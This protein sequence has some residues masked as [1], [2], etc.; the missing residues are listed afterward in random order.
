MKSNL[1][2]SLFA[3]SAVVPFAAVAFA[4][5]PTPAAKPSPTAKAGAK[6]NEPK[7]C[8]GMKCVHAKSEKSHHKC[9]AACHDKHQVAG[10][11]CKKH[12][13]AA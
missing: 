2:R 6:T 8:Q 11:C 13:E 5:T 9:T 10:T 12:K 4:Q 3:V 7:C 1:L